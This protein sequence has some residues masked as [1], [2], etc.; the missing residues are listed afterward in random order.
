MNHINRSLTRYKGTRTFAIS[1][2]YSLHSLGRSQ[3]S[4]SFVAALN[5]ENMSPPM[6]QEK[7]FTSSRNSG[8]N[9]KSTQRRFALKSAPVRSFF[10]HSGRMEQKMMFTDGLPNSLKSSSLGLPSSKQS[11]VQTRA[12]SS[13][14]TS[15]VSSTT[16]PRTATVGRYFDSH[17]GLSRLNSFKYSQ[18]PHVTSD[19]D[20]PLLHI[21]QVILYHK[22]D[23]LSRMRP[24]SLD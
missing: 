24:E 20:A 15:S 21:K 22:D 8:R 16:T 5:S 4:R 10:P 18:F 14:R 19:W 17:N 23:F 12:I 9:I 3:S 1:S 7:T 13:G 6:S 2:T 11:R